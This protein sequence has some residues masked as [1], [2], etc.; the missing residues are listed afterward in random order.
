MA[1]EQDDDHEALRLIR[2]FYAVRDSEARRTIVAI[3]EAA[4]RGT[5]LKI[6]DPAEL[7]AAIHN[8]STSA[9]ENSPH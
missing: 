6:E 4:A 2:A 1:Q 9:R 8:W 5:S 3:V 7:G